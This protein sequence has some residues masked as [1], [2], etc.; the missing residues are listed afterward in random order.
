[1]SN[2]SNNRIRVAVIGCGV[3]GLAMGKHLIV[4]SD[5]FSVTIYE[6]T[7]SIGGT[8]VYTDRIGIDDNGSP[9]HSSMYKN[10]R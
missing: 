7:S 3:A 5:K 4:R 8:W 1:M 9:L 2:V 6:Q 10:L